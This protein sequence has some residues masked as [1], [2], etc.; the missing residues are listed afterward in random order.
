MSPE[1]D[2]DRVVANERRLLDPR[3]RADPDA[4]RAM[5]HEEFTEFGASGTVWS[6]ESI[7]RALVDETAEYI[8]MVDVQVTCLAADAILLTYT[9]HRGDNAS[10]RTSIWLRT[11]GTWQI[12]HHQGTRIRQA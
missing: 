2:F 8:D 11:G 9:A 3:V 7:V 6:R 5:L 12:R 10:R 1:S 4:V